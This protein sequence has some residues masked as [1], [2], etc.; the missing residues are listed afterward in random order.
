MNKGFAFVE[1]EYPHEAQKALEYFENIG[2]KM[3]SQMEPEQLCSIATYEND[4][5][6]E[7]KESWVQ[8]GEQ[9][10][11]NKDESGNV[12]RMDE[13]ESDT[14]IGEKRKREDDGNNDENE[15]KKIKS[16]EDVKESNAEEENANA[17]F[18]GK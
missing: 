2:C 7:E 11:S 9:L 16:S 8:K 12:K 10:V 14:N 13:N 15:S 4:D 18:T 5:Q 6:K 1:F 17:E 3:S